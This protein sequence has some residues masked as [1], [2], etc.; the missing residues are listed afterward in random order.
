MFKGK[1]SKDYYA[2]M[3]PFK[4]ASVAKHEE[5]DEEESKFTKP[6]TPAKAPASSKGSSKKGAKPKS[7]SD[8]MD[9]YLSAPSRHL[10]SKPAN[11]GTKS[12]KKKK[13][14]NPTVTP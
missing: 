11:D 3:H 1:G 10:H 12:K 6:S 7:A 2:D 8:L 9:F 4:R 14:S 5:S 13:K